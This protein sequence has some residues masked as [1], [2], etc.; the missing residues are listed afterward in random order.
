MG[1]RRSVAALATV[2]IIVTMVI[3][4]LTLLA[5]SLVRKA[6]SLY[7]R[8]QSGKLDFGRFFQEFLDALPTWATDLM[9]RFAL[10]NLSAVHERL[11][12]AL[13][14]ASKYL[15]AQALSIGKGTAN[16]IVS[17]LLTLY[18][19]F[20]LHQVHQR[21]PRHVQGQPPRGRR[22]RSTRRSYLLAVGDPHV[23][24]DRVQLQ[25]VMMNLIT[26]SIAAMKDVDGRRELA[27]KSQRAEDGQIA[28]CIS[29]SG[30][31]AAPAAG[32]PD[33]QCVLYDQ[34]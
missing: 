2:L 10:T 29:D 9:N 25:Q 5:A 13:V 16:F 34:A 11:S 3:L 33:L 8:I 6:T 14:Q 18:L 27:I 26:N 23:T 19:L 30:V 22:A 24:G 21:D 15:A 32:G 12:A 1:Q 31:G 20:F 7:E 17:L 28:V 4:P